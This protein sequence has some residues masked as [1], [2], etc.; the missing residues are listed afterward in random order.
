MALTVFDPLLQPLASLVQALMAPAAGIEVDTTTIQLR[1]SGPGAV[2]LYDAGVGTP[3]G[4]GA[5][6]LLT[7]GIAPGTSN[8]LSW[9]GADNSGSTGFAN[10]DADIDAVVNAVFQ[11]ESYDAT[12]LSFAFSVTDPQATSISFDLLFGSDEYPE[13]VDAFV[14]CGVVMVDGVNYALFN[15]DPLHPLSVISP[16]LAAGYFQDNGASILPI[17]YDGVSGRLRIVAPLK[18][19]QSP[20]TI[21]IAI[22]DTGDHI[23]DSGLFIANLAAGRDPGS[24]VVANPGG[25]SA[26]NDI[27]TGS[28]KDEYFDLQAGDD[29][30]YAGGGAD[31]VVAG[32]GNDKVFAGTGDD[33]LK[34]DGG[35]DLLDGGADLDTAVYGGASSAYA[36]SV[37]SLSGAITVD[38]SGQGEG[39][40]VLVGVEQLQFSDGLFAFS[41]PGAT[42]LVTVEPGTP[43]PPPVNHAGVV[44]LTDGWGQPF[45]GPVAEGATVQAALSDADGLSGDE[46][47]Q[48]FRDG[49]QIEGATEFSYVVQE[50][51]ANHSLS[52]QVSYSDANGHA[53]SHSSGGLLVLAAG[54]DGEPVLSLMNVGGPVSAAVHTPLTTLL[55]SAIDQGE[56]P[57]SAMQKIRAALKVPAAV[58][59]LLSTNAFQILQSGVGDTASALALAKLEVQVAILCSTA[60]ANPT[61]GS[62][63]TD[64]GGAALTALLL[65]RAANGQTVNLANAGDLA[66]LHPQLAGTPTLTMLVERNANIGKAVTLLGGGDSIETEWADF[67]S[68]WDLSL[69]QIPLTVLS[70]AINQAPVGSAT[71]VLPGALAGEPFTLSAALLTQ[72]FHDPDGDPLT[73]SGLS[74]ELGDWFAD[75]GDGTFSIDPTAAGYDPAYVGP[76]EL[77]Y[78]VA[79]GHG[80]SLAASQLLL[81]QHL[82][83]AATGSLSL[84]GA[85]QE[86]ESLVASLSNLVD[87]DGAT[88]V[89]Y[90]WQTLK[91][92]SWS[93]ITGATGA[94]LAI[95]LGQNYAG[96]QVRV[97]ATSSDA[98]GGS[99]EFVGEPRTVA[100]ALPP[101]PS[102]ALLADTGS[103][104][105]DGLTNNGTIQVSGLIAG[106][107]WQVSLNGGA[108]TAGSGSSF[109]LAAGS[110]GPGSIAVR[111]SNAAGVSASATNA[112]AI[113]VDRS[114]PL[115]PTLALVADTGKSATD[116]ITG[117]S[118]FAVGQLEAGASWEV[119]LNGGASWSAGSGAG[120]SAPDGTYAAG[121]IAV[122]QRD[123]AGNL[124]AIRATTAS[125]TIDTQ[126]PVSPSF[127][128]T[129]DSGSS[130]SDQISNNGAVTVSGLLSGHTWQYSSNG[131]AS[132][133]AAQAATTTSFKLAAASYGPGAVAVRQLDLAG[134]A[135]PASANTAP[136]RI[137]TT[138]PT[139]TSTL[140]GGTSLVVRFSEPVAFPG[141]SAARFAV[142]NGST[143]V[144]INGVN[145]DGAGTSVTL[146]LA[147]AIAS[148][149]Q[150]KV[151]YSDPTTANDATGALEDL[152]GNDLASRS[153]TAV[154]LY[155]A[156]T[157]VSMASGFHSG[158]KG[159][160]LTA[161]AGNASLTGNASANDLTGN[162]APN[163]LSG[164]GGADAL[165]GGA[166]AD[167]FLYASNSD[168][169]LGTSTAP[170]YDRIRDLV[171]GTDTITMATAFAAPAGSISHRGT[172]SA[173]S[174]AAIATLLPTTTFAAGTAAA[175]SLGSGATSR[176]FLV[177]NDSVAGYQAATDGLIEITGFS[178]SLGALAVL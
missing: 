37:D 122:R 42:T 139:V 35:N 60:I 38:A 133:S 65:E 121:A 90:R 131:G 75:N 28:A 62:Y 72:G 9:Y 3:L 96:A 83:H 176:S 54:G 52:A 93:D 32:S 34:G 162:D 118:A 117:N 111:Q 99:T 18:A 136:I 155:L 88:T 20:H 71:A 40:D 146:S 119:S 141:A 5:G 91:D 87:A 30:V 14:D 48:W 166:G 12:S 112:A 107:P 68:N 86:G 151:S 148:T 138:L 145:V 154:P 77:H 137:D 132:W 177:L 45:N 69:S 160:E 10:G 98:L 108:W 51:D 165:T 66:A 21:K 70:Q 17:E 153:A 67:I 6:V 158:Y 170:R 116:R 140:V 178:G 15:N 125:F 22:A 172:A 31:I 169:L 78:T 157:S 1:S 41:A 128:L 63:S 134:N 44:V 89:A 33:Q 97:V 47:V 110:Y 142:L 124:G 50:G 76:L 103:S 161:A 94:T 85:A 171:I 106:N 79:D 24:G 49:Q 120:F 26:G 173:L 109:T 46:A 29:T 152:A 53:E 159:V 101:A 58:T 143:S 130:P 36:L 16:N 168:S 8:T 126:A 81:V 27:C 144:A 59:N 102:F 95:P 61:N 4:I 127:Q 147:S 74:T 55:M 175:F 43:P 100:P 123:G 105:S 25:G 11:T 64:P 156:S 80:H 39:V 113:T 56:T 129:V 149:S 135:S 19:G 167:E 104:A 115:A 84:S 13:W 73:V 2:S 23:L 7:S 163:V 174:E 82:D 57:N 92:S 164:G 150:V 114:A